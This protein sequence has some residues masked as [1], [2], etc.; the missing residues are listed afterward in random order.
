M[1]EA[2][3]DEADCALQRDALRGQNQMHVIRHD[4]KCVQL[5]VTEA[6]VMLKGLEEQFGVRAR[7]K[8]AAGIVGRGGYEVSA[9]A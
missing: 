8:Q 5:V 2:S 4:D 1:R 3:L 7:L 9:G 6:P